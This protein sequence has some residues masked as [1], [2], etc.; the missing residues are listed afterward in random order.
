ML[1]M[2]YFGSV[3]IEWRWKQSSLVIDYITADV[4]H[5]TG[6][7]TCC[8]NQWIPGVEPEN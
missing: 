2:L 7:V 8:E 5:D 1:K 6:F 4:T 3:V